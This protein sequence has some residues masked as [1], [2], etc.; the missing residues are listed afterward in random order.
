MMARNGERG[1]AL[2]MVLSVLMALM[3]LAAPFL[4]IAQNDSARSSSHWARSMVR[5]RSEQTL[6]YARY[7]LLAGHEAEESRRQGGNV[8]LLATPLTDVPEESQVTIDLVDKQGK[9]RLDENGAPMNRDIRGMLVDL[10]V[11]EEQAFPN[12]LTAPPFLIASVLGRSTLSEKLTKTQDQITVENG[13]GF[14]KKDGRLLINGEIVSYDERQGNTFM[15][16]TRGVEGGLRARAHKE[17][18]WVLDDRARQVAMLPFASPRSGGGHREPLEASYIKE[19][20]LLG[21]DVLLPTEVDLLLSNFTTVGRRVPADGFGPATTVTAF[22]DPANYDG[23]GFLI[24]VA[25]TAGFNAGTVVRLSDGKDFEYLMVAE[26][27]GLLG[28]GRLRTFQPPKRSYQADQATVAPLARH[29]VNMNSASKEVLIRIFNGVQLTLGGRGGGTFGR[30][31]EDAAADVASGIIDNRPVRDFKHLREILEEVAANHPIDFNPLLAQ[32][33]FRNIVDPGDGRLVT[34]TVPCSFRSFDYYSTEAVAVLNNQSGTELARHRIRELIHVAPPGLLSLDLSTQEDFEHWIVRGR[35]GRWVATHPMPTAGFTRQGE[36]PWDRVNRMLFRF[37]GALQGGNGQDPDRDDVLGMNG[38][39]PDKDQGDVRLLPARMSPRPAGFIEHFDGPGGF[40][41]SAVTLDRIDPEGFMLENGPFSWDPRRGGGLISMAR[42]N[43]QM[44]RAATNQLPG[45]TRGSLVGG[46]NVVP[47]RVDLWYRFGSGTGGR[48]VLFDLNGNDPKEDRIQLVRENDGSLRGRVFGRTLDD[49]ADQL[50]EVAEVRWFPQNPGFWQ[51]KTWYHFGLAYRG[52]KP[53]DLTLFVDGMKRGESIFQSHLSGNFDEQATTFTV[54]NAD[55]WPNSGVCMVGPEVIAFQRNGTSFDVQALN[56]NSMWGRGQ[57]GTKIM[58]HSSGE[59]VE[60]FGY[61]ILPRNAVGGRG[62][63]VPSGGAHLRDGISSLKVAT[64][65]GNFVQTFPPTQ[66]G[67]PPIR[68]MVH[69]PNQ[70][71]GNQ[72]E[73]PQGQDW[74]CFPASGGYVLIVS[75]GAGPVPGQVEFARYSGR[76]GNILNG[77]SAV[78]SPPNPRLNQNQTAVATIRSVHP[79]QLITGLPNPPPRAVVI[80]LSIAVD[81]PQGLKT[82]EKVQGGGG[83]NLPW[84]TEPEFVQLGQQDFNDLSQHDIEWIRYHHIDTQGG[85]LVL[86]EL[87][88]LSAAASYLRGL[89]PGTP[90]PTGAATAMIGVFPQRS[91]CGT[92]ETIGSFTGGNHASGSEALP[93]IR[94]VS[95]SRATSVNI[96]S[97]GGAA[98]PGT[99]IEAPSTGAAWSSAGWGDQVTIEGPRGRNSVRARVSWAGVESFTIGSGTPILPLRPPYISTAGN[100][101][102]VPQP[103]SG[104]GWISLSK[105]TGQDYRQSGFP[106]AGTDAQRDRYLRIL[107]FPSGELPRIGRGARVAAGGSVDGQ[108]GSTDGRLDEVRV[109]PF[110]QERFVVWDHQGMNLAST[111]PSLRS[112][113]QATDTIPIANVDWAVSLG[114]R[115]NYSH[116]HLADGRRVAYNEALRGLP[117]NEAGLVKIGEEIIAFRNIGTGQGGGPAL[118]ECTRGF[119]NTIPTPHGPGERVVFLDFVPI[120]KLTG[121]FGPQQASM[122]LAQINGFQ[123]TGGSVLIGTEVVHY[124]RITA[125]S[126]VMPW[127]IDAEGEVDGGLFRGRFGTSVQSHSTDDLVMALPFRYWDRYAEGQDAAALSWYGLSLDLP[128]AFFHRI[129][130]EELKRGNLTDIVVL[131]RSDQ[132]V[133]WAADPRS[134]K[135]LFLFDQ[136]NSEEPA[137]LNTAG[138]GLELRVFFRYLQGAMN[139]TTMEVH[140]WKRSAELRRLSVKYFDETRVLKRESTR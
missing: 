112:V 102:T 140:D 72:L 51:S 54:D 121:A 81:N 36:M 18:T 114:G 17:D 132:T 24:P 129:D 65:A 28:P 91:Q 43:L 126:L 35:L 74:S 90:S 63:V 62:V 45:S 44:G 139:P 84:D 7:R 52:T 38:L 14:K 47:A 105:S 85:H 37:K 118:L 93:C 98:A 88:I 22:L 111:P 59:P 71:N 48:H 92:F 107:K 13:E 134:T 133:S 76:S 101:N 58:R 56:A 3:V 2:V 86:D 131:A 57:R 27:R 60:L 127:A 32:A 50:T 130:F 77:L 31:D 75:V 82:P 95:F 97:A 53:A 23:N 1:V 26:V 110:I 33:V 73:L 49:P 70:P 42:S 8:D 61:S 115:T 69:D 104:L 106:T 136:G 5:L 46:R 128:D 68:V 116:Y 94:T 41:R 99:P 15:G 39:F 40:S 6:R 124:T 30:M 9:P 10:H 108:V 12:L 113:D 20:A 122:A 123:P 87:P 120:S 29:P 100:N 80:P 66:Q 135:G 64:F 34:S 78:A 117:A 67:Q 16:C 138:G 4:M 19:L 119:M 103:A 25:S 96:P 83:G 55:D 109:T 125:G 89:L 137:L 11:R 79:V 21:N